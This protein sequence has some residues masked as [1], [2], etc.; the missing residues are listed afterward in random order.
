MIRKK[1]S[2]RERRFHSDSYLNGIRAGIIS[3]KQAYEMLSRNTIMSDKERR[4]FIARLQE[5]PFQNCPYTIN[6]G[7]A[8]EACARMKEQEK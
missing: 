2:K 8:I 7:A 4:N 1:N 3:H 6:T 5:I